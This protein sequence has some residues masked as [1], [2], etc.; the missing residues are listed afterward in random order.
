MR[1]SGLAGRCGTVTEQVLAVPG[2]LIGC[3]VLLD[4][5]FQNEHLWFIPQDALEDE[6][7][8]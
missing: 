3:M 2:R 8:R 7:D 1:L 5:P 4:K 6:A